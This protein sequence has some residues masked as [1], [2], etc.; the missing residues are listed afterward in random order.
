MN[1]DTITQ[2]I[3]DNKI[4]ILLIVAYVFY[5]KMIDPAYIVGIILIYYCYMIS[6]NI[7]KI[8]NDIKNLKKKIN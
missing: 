8:K 4:I 3:F 2:F 7:E 5:T 6:N 1:F